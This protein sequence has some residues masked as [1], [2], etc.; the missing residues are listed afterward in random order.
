MRILHV[1]YIYPPKL[2]VADGIT[3]VAYNVTKELAKMGH[4]VVV[5]TSNMLDLHG[6]DSLV[7]GNYVVNDVNVFYSKSIFHSNTIIATPGLLP[8]LIKS[9]FDIIHIHDCRS[10]QGLSAYL[11]GKIKKTPIVFQPHG[12]YLSS[13]PKSLMAKIVR[14]AVD[15]TLSNKVVKNASKIIVLSELEAKQYMDI[16]VPKEKIEIIP[17][18]I[19]LSFYLNSGESGFFKKYNLDSD[20]K[21]IGYLGRINRTKGIAFLVKAFANLI[22][23]K[24]Y[25]SVFLI[26]AGPDDGYLAEVMKLINSLGITQRVVFTGLLTEEEKLSVYADLDIVVNVEPENVYGL[27]PIEAA[28]CSKPVI[29]SEGNAIVDIVRQGQFGVT[30]RNGCIN[31][32]SNALSELLSNNALRKEMGRKGQDFIFKT[33]SW[34]RI[35]TKYEKVYREISN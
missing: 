20:K 31:D 27:V 13:P 18:G 11:A 7:P 4:E 22:K 6:D 25:G 16:D 26:I 2:G 32:L 3:S 5:Y 14:S 21:K 17:N 29:V 9:N 30:V 19:D 10:F 24:K 15:I 35:V 12:S 8:T 1:T 23:E 33:L 28:A 34:N